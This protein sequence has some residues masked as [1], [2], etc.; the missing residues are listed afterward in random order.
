MTNRMAEIAK[1]LGVEV[2]EVFQV[3]GDPSI[4]DCFFKFSD[5]D[6]QLSAVNGGNDTWTAASDTRL[7]DIL[8]GRLR[9][10][11]LPRKPAI[12]DMYCYPDPATPLLWWRCSWRDDEVDNYR[13]QHGFVFA[14]REEAIT[15]TK[16]ML[17]AINEQ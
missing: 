2:G 7:L 11:K 5:N 12:G 1:L 16:K 17:E 4:K 13:L 14:T 9:I 6:L 3:D 10:R 8:Y 15:K